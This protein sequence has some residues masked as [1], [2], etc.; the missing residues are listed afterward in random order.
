MIDAFYSSNT[1][2]NMIFLDKASTWFCHARFSSISTPRDL[3]HC[4]RL[5]GTLLIFKE[6]REGRLLSFCL[7]RNSVLIIFS[8][9]LFAVSQRFMLTKSSFRKDWMEWIYH[10]NK[11]DGYHLH[12]FLAQSETDSWANHWYIAKTVEALILFPRE[13]HTWG[14]NILKGNHWQRI[15]EYDYLNRRRKIYG[16]H[17]LDH[18][19]VI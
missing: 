17:L 7:E 16:K 18:R 4:E 11:S 2:C 6:G 1:R 13:Y 10:S 8:V 15:S 19:D 3:E 5:I 9:N 12:T 14:C